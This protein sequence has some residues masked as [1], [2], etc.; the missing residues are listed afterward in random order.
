MPPFLLQ[1]LISM[2]QIVACLT[3]MFYAVRLYKLSGSYRVPIV[4][5]VV[6]FG[7]SN[8][9]FDLLSTLIK[10]AAI[11][12]TSIWRHLQRDCAEER[13]TVQPSAPKVV[14]GLQFGELHPLGQLISTE[15][16]QIWAG[17]S[18]LCDVVIAYFMTRYVR[19]CPLVD[20]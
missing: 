9:F 19:L 17:G 18:A 11:S 13:R 20:C 5:S 7:F 4:V 14:Q 15:C 6:R 8:L 1:G 12:N 2:H 3:Q 10:P 16:V